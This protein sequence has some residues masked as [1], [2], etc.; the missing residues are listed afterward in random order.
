MH[1]DIGTRFPWNCT[2][3]GKAIVAFLPDVETKPLLAG[4]LVRRTPVSVQS[5]LALRAH[6]EKIKA[7]GYATDDGENNEGVRC[8]AAPIFDSAGRPVAAIS[9]SGY[10]GQIPLERLTKLGQVVSKATGTVSRSLGYRP[11]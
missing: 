3:A 7:A 11:K 6:F 4:K 1:V 9:L 2:S 5:A 8:V 10:I